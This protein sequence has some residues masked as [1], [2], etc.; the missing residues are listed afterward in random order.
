MPRTR[1]DFREYLFDYFLPRWGEHGQEQSGAFR[2]FLNHDWT[3]GDNPERRLRVQ[4]RQTWVFARAASLGAHDDAK[5]AAIAGFDYLLDNFHDRENGGFY[6]ML[7]PD[8]KPLDRSKELYEHAFVL[9][10]CAG[11]HIATGSERAKQTA[12]EVYGLL[13]KHL[14]DPKH[15]GFFEGASET[16]EPRRGARRQNPHM[17]LFE[18]LLAWHETD[19]DGRWGERARAILDLFYDHFYDQEADLLREHFTEDW[20]PAP[21]D[22]GKVVEPGHHFEWIFLLEE[23]ARLFGQAQW[24]DATCGL[25]DWGRAHGLDPNGGAYD[26]CWRDGSAKA[27]TKRVWPQTE[28]LRTLSIRYRDS[29]ESSWHDQIEAHLDWMRESYCGDIFPGWKE[30][31]SPGGEIITN[32]Q[33]AT[34]VYHIFGAFITLM[35]AV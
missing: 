28:W 20:Q 3:P 17:H 27:A 6:L 12:E 32:E 10:A 22:A 30:Q 4:A 1:E 35:D 15:G 21:G 13:E 24:G 23:Y 18:A 8:G 19:P 16:W 11:V 14:A 9:L 34:S 31:L 25:W 7:T 5:K 2:Y 29:L 26:E 33:R